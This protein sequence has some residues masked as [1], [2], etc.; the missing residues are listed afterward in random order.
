MNL[1]I[2]NGWDIHRLIEGRRLIIGGVII[3][4]EKG[5]D[6]HSD[7]D[8]LLH[9]LIDALLGSIASGDIGSHF[10]P[11]DDR[12]KDADSAYLL[13]L[14]M[15]ELH[16]KGARPINI[17]CTVILQEPKLRPYVSSIRAH[18]ARLVDLPFE[19]VS[20][21]A[22]TAEHILGEL[23]RGEAIEAHATVLVSLDS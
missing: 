2:G 10:P 11:S 18:I 16:Q 9:A 19:A 12:W 6:A 23:G 20:V 14:V 8:V 21:K 13:T 22:K 4:H 7:G 1:R 15:E 3:P 17:D 5:E